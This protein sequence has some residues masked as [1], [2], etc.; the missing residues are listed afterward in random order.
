MCNQLE[1]QQVIR[2]ALRNSHQCEILLDLLEELWH[3]A[4][5]ILSVHDLARQRGIEMGLL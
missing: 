4:D 3:R 5:P 2:N 1:W